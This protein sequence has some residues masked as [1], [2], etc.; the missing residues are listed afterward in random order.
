MKPIPNELIIAMPESVEA[1]KESCQAA[2]DAVL[3][4]LFLMGAELDPKLTWPPI[5]SNGVELWP[6][7]PPYESGERRQISLL[8]NLNGRDESGYLE[9]CKRNAEEYNRALEEAK[10]YVATEIAK[11]GPTDATHVWNYLNSLAFSVEDES[12]FRALELSDETKES[13]YR[14][15][16]LRSA[17]T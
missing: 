16:G 1:T 9:H 7:P 12:V 2:A 10:P 17:H 13:Y 14:A 15:V 8:I 5:L 3:H 6:M 11:M 4:V